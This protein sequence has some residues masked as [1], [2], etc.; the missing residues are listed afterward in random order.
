LGTWCDALRRR[1]SSEPQAFCGLRSGQLRRGGANLECDGVRR[2]VRTRRRPKLKGF[3]PFRPIQCE[4]ECDGCDGQ[5]RTLQGS[6][7]QDSRGFRAV[8]ATGKCELRTRNRGLSLA[9]YRRAPPRTLLRPGRT[10]VFSVLAEATARWRRFCSS[11]RPA[12]ATSKHQAKLSKAKQPA[13]E[14]EGLP[15]QFFQFWD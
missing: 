11:S 5:V 12:E 1:R 15:K 8:S 3:R 2:L 13:P 10:R 4:P 14:L 9:K 7:V 6:E